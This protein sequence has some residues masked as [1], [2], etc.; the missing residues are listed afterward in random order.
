MS[1]KLFF[2][3]N[4]G[5]YFQGTSCPFDGWSMDGLAGVVAV[6]QRMTAAGLVIDL[7]SLLAPEVSSELKRRV[8][9][10]EFGDDAAAFQAL[11]PERYIH[12]GEELP[13]HRVPL[14][15]H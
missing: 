3:C 10:I 9:L 11:A 12:G 4:G 15:L 2:R 1:K 6:F 7:R 13:W 14:E 5:H 8:L